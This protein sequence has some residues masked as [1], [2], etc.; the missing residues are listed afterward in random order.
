[1]D[2]FEIV[3]RSALIVG[4][5]QPFIDWIRSLDPELPVET[6]GH[7]NKTV[8]L[9]PDFDDENEWREYLR[10]HYEE[11]FEEELRTWSTDES[12]LPQNMSWELFNEWFDIETQSMVLDMVDREIEKE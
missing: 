3:H 4:M 1:M 8:Y 10:E 2:Y 7:D 9:I 12:E 11:I 5:K 6:E